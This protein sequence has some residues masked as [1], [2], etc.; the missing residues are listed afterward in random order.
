MQKNAKPHK[1]PE[2]DYLRKYLADR[3]TKPPTSFASCA[4]CGH[5]LVYE[6]ALN[7]EGAQENKAITE[8]WLQDHKKV[9]EYLQR[10]CNPL[11][12]A[13]LGLLANLKETRK[14]K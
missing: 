12:D 5:S 8:K 11:L 10:N 13:A 2:K 7:K 14:I 4:M 3:A 1:I 6:L 9:E